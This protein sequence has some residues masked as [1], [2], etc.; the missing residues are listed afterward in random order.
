MKS[1][2]FGGCFYWGIVRRCNAFWGLGSAYFSR[3]FQPSISA[4]HKQRLQRLV[5][6][7]SAPVTMHCSV[8]GSAIRQHIRR[9][10]M[11]TRL[12]NARH[13]ALQTDLHLPCQDKTPLRAAGAMELAAKANR[14]LAQ[15]HA[16]TGKQW[17]QHGL[18]VAFGQGDQFL[19][20]ARAAIGVGKQNNFGEM[21]HGNQCAQGLQCE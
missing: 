18:R 16:A 6:H 21:G 20:K 10:K 5:A 17:R 1:S 4:A 12:E 9:V 13:T 8:K 3:P 7:L 11:F 14:T 15:L 2:L 19:A